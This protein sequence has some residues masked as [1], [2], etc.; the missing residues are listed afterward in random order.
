VAPVRC[1]LLT[2]FA[3]DSVD[4]VVS[5]PPYVAESMRESMQREVRD[6]EP[7]LA[8]FGGGDGLEVYRRLIPE[9]W[10]V[11]RLGGH[12]VLE[13]GF[14]SLPEVERRLPVPVTVHKDLAGIARVLVCQKR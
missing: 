14:D 10:R 8:L 3:D 9:A 13:L 5:N 6:W 4:L 7:G 2:A 12:L 1:D 11:L